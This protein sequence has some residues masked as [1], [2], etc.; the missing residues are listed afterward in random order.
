MPDVSLKKLLNRSDLWCAANKAA[1]NQSISTGVSQLDKAL[2]QGGWPCYGLTEFLLEAPGCGELRLIA[3]ALAHLSQR[4]GLLTLI[5]PPY[6]PYAPGL[7]AYGIDL[8]RILVIRTK[9][10]A[11]I[12]WATEQAL[13]SGAC[14][15]VLSWLPDKAVRHHQIR[16]LQLA[17][18]KMHGLAV[19]LRPRQIAQQHSPAALRIEVSLINHQY[20]LN[21]LKQRGGWGGQRIQLP[22]PKL[23]TQ[24]QIPTNQL[25]VYNGRLSIAPTAPKSIQP[26]ADTLPVTNPSH[27]ALH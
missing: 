10:T 18:Q 3:P 1:K 5:A 9:S 20:E 16:K 2:H 4:P 6:I 12:L 22:L 13:R 14:S 11:E 17:A 26:L 19:L 23:L 7:L 24:R 15:S 21:I 27:M 8:S 25:P